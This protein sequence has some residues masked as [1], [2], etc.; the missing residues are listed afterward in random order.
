MTLEARAGRARLADE[1]LRLARSLLVGGGGTLLD[2]AAVLLALRV[3]ELEATWARS[4]GLCVGCV[5]MFYGSRSFAFRAES[6]SAARQARRFVVSEVIGF[7]L[8]ILVFRALVVAL[9]A[10]APEALS[11]VANFALFLVYYYPVRNFVVFRSC[12]AT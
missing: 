10:A 11:L 1:G 2:F 5:V 12:P 4:L 6:D 8:N 9:P 7:P 3:L